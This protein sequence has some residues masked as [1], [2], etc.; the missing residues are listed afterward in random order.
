MNS[1]VFELLEPHRIGLEIR[2]GREKA[3]LLLGDGDFLYPLIHAERNL[4]LF[5]RLLRKGRSVEGLLGIFAAVA[6]T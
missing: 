1:Q 6:T 5:L 3:G 2:Q 4:E